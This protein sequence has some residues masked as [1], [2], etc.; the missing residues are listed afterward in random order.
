MAN[1]ETVT[2]TVAQTDFFLP[3]LDAD[4]LSCGIDKNLNVEIGK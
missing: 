1:V 3:T 2:D 4:T